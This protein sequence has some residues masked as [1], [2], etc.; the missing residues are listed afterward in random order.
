MSDPIGVC[1]IVVSYSG[2]QITSSMHTKE[3]S[4]EHLG[5]LKSHLQV[6]D[7][8][9]E[10]ASEYPPCLSAEK[11]CDLDKFGQ[12]TVITTFDTVAFCTDV[13]ETSNVVETKPG[14]HLIQ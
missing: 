9:S 10:V 5:I 1:L 7:K 11:G 4:K 3:V 13:C 8:Y 2:A 12:G 6:G 14:F